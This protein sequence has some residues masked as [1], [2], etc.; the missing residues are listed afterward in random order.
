MPQSLRRQVL[1]ALA[2]VLIAVLA[3]V[4]SVD[5]VAEHRDGGRDGRAARPPV[6]AVS[7]AL[8]RPQLFDG[9]MFVAY[10]GTVGTPVLGVLGEAAPWKAA[11]RVEKAAAPFRRA[12][13]KPQPVF[14]LIVTIADRHPGPDGDYNH[15]VPAVAVRRW[16]AA[17]RQ[18]GAL[19]VLDVQPGRADFPSVAK[20]W[21]S[22]LADPNVSLALDPEWRMHGGQVPGRT[23]GSTTGWEINLT[24][25]WLQ[26]FVVAH[27]LPQKLFVVH[28]FRRDMIRGID[29]VRDRPDLAEIQHVDGFGTPGQKLATYRA[30]AR[31]DLFRMGFKLFYDEDIRRLSAQ[32]VM[33]IRPR[34]D[35]VSFQ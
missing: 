18:S 25:R 3:L 4:Q 21:A 22:A 30:V 6:A 9:R 7:P 2:V 27:H 34:V 24:S 31:P 12:G 23:I 28:Q 26:D 14:E 29:I 35:F 10:Y 8:E 19:L 13:L 17:A 32:Q 20:R 11:A 1:V 16:I 15:D 33:R 5:S